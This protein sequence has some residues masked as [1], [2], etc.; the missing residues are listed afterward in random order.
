MDFMWI[1]MTQAEKYEK[2]PSA[3]MQ[4]KQNWVTNG[5]WWPRESPA[6]IPLFNLIFQTD[7]RTN[8]ESSRE[9]KMKRIKSGILCDSFISLSTKRTKE[10]NGKTFYADSLLSR[11]RVSVKSLFSESSL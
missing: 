2:S 8:Q 1:K 10:G 5:M 6:F 3:W 9:K 7:W 4:E 11:D